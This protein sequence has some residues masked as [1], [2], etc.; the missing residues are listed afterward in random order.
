MRAV[1]MW[2]TTWAWVSIGS[3]EKRGRS[4]RLLSVLTQATWR[5]W[6][7]LHRV[8]Q[9]LSSSIGEFSLFLTKV[10][11]LLLL[12]LSLLLPLRSLW[13]HWGKS[14]YNVCCV[15]FLA[16]TRLVN[17]W[18]PFYCMAMPHLLVRA[19]STRLF[20]SATSRL[21]PP[22]APFILL[23]I[24]RYGTKSF[25]RSLLLNQQRLTFSRVYSFLFLKPHY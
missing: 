18:C 23:S 14:Y 11:S 5:R 20:I 13:W 22:G 10:D 7:L 25:I 3:T 1:V 6:T 15:I 24:I 2:S 16:K 4:L 9:E 17:R 21:I 12:P 8:K 19:S